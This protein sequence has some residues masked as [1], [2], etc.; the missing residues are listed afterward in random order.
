MKE[1]PPEPDSAAHNYLSAVIAAFARLRTDQVILETPYYA[2]LARY[3]PDVAALPASGPEHRTD[4]SPVDGRAPAPPTTPLPPPG[5]ARLAG[6]LWSQLRRLRALHASPPSQPLLIVGMAS[7]RLCFQAGFSGGRAHLSALTATLGA[8]DIANSIQQ[9]I[10]TAPVILLFDPLKLSRLWNWCE[11]YHRDNIL[12]VDG[13]FLAGFAV[14]HPFSSLR[15]FFLALA[16]ARHAPRGGFRSVLGANLVTGIYTRLLPAGVAQEAAFL[17]SNSYLTELLRAHLIRSRDCRLIEELMHGIGSIPAERFFAAVLAAGESFGS[18]AKHY[19]IPQMPGL[20]LYGVFARQA[21]AGYDFAINAYLNR[22][23]LSHATPAQLE[24]TIVGEAGKFDRADTPLVITLFGNFPCIG[25]P[26]TSE[27]FAAERVLLALL[28]RILPTLPRRPLVVYAPHPLYHSVE[29]NDPVFAE[30]DVMVYRDSVFCWLVSDGCLSLM[31]SAMFEAAHFGA[32][33]F[34]PM[35]P[36]DNFYTA[37]YLSLLVH[38]DSE[39]LTHLEASLRRFLTEA[40]RAPAAS[41]LEK[42]RRRLAALRLALN[43]VPTQG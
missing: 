28:A 1:R 7:N 25:G 37:G 29:F 26:F 31:S 43:P 33:V 35:L 15:A 2:R 36:K 30:H 9:K 8:A 12:I 3:L 40:C 27:S 24:Q 11:A 14:T 18:Y 20:P 32:T 41:P 42:A 38:P 19:F 22:Y 4:A 23:L 6:M 39:S 17:T 10:R 16:A 5:L 34:T 13:I 21:R